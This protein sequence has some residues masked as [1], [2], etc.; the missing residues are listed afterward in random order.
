MLRVLP[1]KCQNP[2]HPEPFDCAQDKLREGSGVAGLFC[3]YLHHPRFEERP[4]LRE[5]GNKGVRAS[6]GF[7]LLE[8]A[9]A[10]AVITMILAALLSTLASAST[11]TDHAYDRSVLFELAQS[12]MEDV[13]RQAYS[14]SAASYTKITAPAGYSIALATTPAVTYT[15]PAPLSTTTQETV[16]LVTVTVTG[17]RGNLDLKAYKVR[18]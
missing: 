5:R 17:V 10:L 1:N 3:H 18:R 9:V 8:T 2:C 15:Y 7:S 11:T 14:V 16:Q 4:A 13:Q 6:P 12:Q